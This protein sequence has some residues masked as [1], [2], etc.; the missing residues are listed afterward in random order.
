VPPPRDRLRALL[1]LV[2][3]SLDASGADGRAPEA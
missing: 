2:A 3:G 1:D